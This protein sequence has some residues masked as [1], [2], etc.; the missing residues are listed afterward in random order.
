MPDVLEEL[1][2]SPEASAGGKRRRRRR[3]RSRLSRIRTAV[4]ARSATILTI[5]LV[6]AVAGS[7]LA[8]GTVHVVSLLLVAPVALAAGVIAIWVEDESKRRLPLPA[9]IAA[10]L[11]LYSL[12]QSLPMPQHWLKTLSPGATQTWLDAFKLAGEPL[13]RWASL[14]VDP[15]ASRVEALKW[16]CYAAI[17]IAAARL[18]RQKGSQRG[19]S[20]V[21]GSALLGG[22]LCL[23][24]G[25]FGV[26]EWLGLYKPQMA[27]PPWA[28]APLLNPNNFAGYLNLGLFA[29]LGMLFVRK[30]LAPRWALGLAVAILAA[31]VILTGSRGG[32]LALVIG[33]GIAGL[34]YRFQQ[35]RAAARN[36]FVFPA[37]LP[38]TGVALAALALALIGAT[39]VIWQQLLDE[40][41][42][43]LRIVEYSRPVIRDYLWTGIGRGS[44]ETAFAAYRQEPGNVIAQYAENFVVQWIVEWGLP[45]AVIALASFTWT[46]RPQRLGFG[47]NALP[48]GAFVGISVLLLQ[49]LVD[50]ATE[51]ASVGIATSMLLGTLVGGAEYFADTRAKVRA[52]RRETTQ[53]PTPTHVS[54]TRPSITALA[55]LLSGLCLVWLVARTGHPDA[56]DERNQLAEQL[57]SLVGKPKGDP[58]FAQSH[59]AL[60]AALLRHPADPYLPI[61]GALLT[62][63][64]GKSPYS[65]LNQALRRDP[66]NSMPHLLL[67]ETLAARG[68]MT[69][70]L[71]ELRRTFELE[72]AML[73]G[74][75][76]RA[77][78]W[79]QNVEDLLR[80]VPDGEKGIPMLNALAQRFAATP[81]RIALR[82]ELLAISLRRN[83]RDVGTNS[84]YAQDL[85]AKM[86]METGACSGDG[87]AACSEQLQQHAA[88]VMQGSTDRQTS[89]ILRAKLLAHDKKYDEAERSLAENCERLPDPVSCGVDRVS[90]AMKLKDP[91][92]FD[93]AA[94]AYTA[95]ACSTS[96]TC[97]QAFT[98]LGSLELGRNN[99]LAA[100]SRYERAAQ[101][102]PSADAWLRVADV[103]I[104]LGRIGRSETAMA[105]A[106]RLGAAEG[107]V[108]LDRK[109]QDLQRARMLEDVRLSSPRTTR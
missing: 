107:M 11:A 70:A 102:T 77:V 23:V 74:V 103:A 19:A 48:T 79:T 41:T 83:R 9:W 43:K 81:E 101:E 64:S 49:N 46:M 87:R 100:L 99:L 108:D 45:V 31:L 82:E 1:P 17:F 105:A 71:F 15:G 4:Q 84:I 94:S 26:T 57:T 25:L 86:A 63:E 37:W 58:G 92:R 93:E 59:Q 10:G 6:L 38:L 66:L 76:D 7:L 32:V 47:R 72:P 61:I 13:A 8:V 109:L 106:R 39:D 88:A 98:W 36:G 69:Q 67:A 44:F 22:I 35:A 62:R 85:L 90:Y 14:S 54:S 20:I 91:A 89:A 68:A 65:W 12:L 28:P 56:I 78:R 16:L 5:L 75:A 34:A 95:A 96:A 97:A 24:H 30:P 29:G 53:T 52:S 73:G 60:A 51:V 80:A 18:A 3:R 2:S 104:R 33:F 27:Q 40:T 50:L 55:C 21:V 42:G